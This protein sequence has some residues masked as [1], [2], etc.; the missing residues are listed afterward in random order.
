VVR[1]A[2]DVIDDVQAVSNDYV[3]QIDYGGERP[4]RVVP[5]PVQYSAT[6]AFSKRAPA[7]M[8]NTD[9]VLLDLGLTY[10]AIMELKIAG[11]IA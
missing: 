5:A 2:G 1:E 4:L 7:P 8:S 9:E 11:A 10:D 6:G 3:Q